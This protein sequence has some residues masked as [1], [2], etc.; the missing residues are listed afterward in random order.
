MTDIFRD[1]RGSIHRMEI[2]GQ[3][4]NVL[5][6]KAGSYRSGDWHPHRQFDVVISGRADVQLRHVV[7]DGSR[8]LCPGGQLVIRPNTPHLFYFPEDTVMIEWWDGPLVV[9]YYEP[10]RKIV[11]DSLRNG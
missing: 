4:F 3:K 5:Y 10:W 11:E 9:N 2:G 8:L 1:S 6:T 7:G